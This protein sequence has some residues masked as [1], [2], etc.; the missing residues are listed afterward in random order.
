MCAGTRLGWNQVSL[1]QMGFCV[2]MQ[3]NEVPQP[4]ENPPWVLGSP[5]IWILELGS[6]LKLSAMG[7][8]AGY[9]VELFESWLH[10]C[11]S[12]APLE[13]AL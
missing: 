9:Q 8:Q 11:D 13:V 3:P 5:L 4:E 2:I 1:K 7:S 12:P 6:K 10:D